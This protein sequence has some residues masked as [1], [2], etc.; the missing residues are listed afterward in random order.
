[1]GVH[2]LNFDLSVCAVPG[3]G[4]RMSRGKTLFV[5]VIEYV[6]TCLLIAK[7]ELHLDASRYTCLQILSISIFE[8]RRFHVSF[9]PVGPKQNRPARLTN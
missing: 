4:W 9:S 3:F 8:K 2:D 6:A 7:E 5:Q 1:M